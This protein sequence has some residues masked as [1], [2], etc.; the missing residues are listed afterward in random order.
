MEAMGLH[1]TIHLMVVEQGV[2]EQEALDLKIAVLLP[3]LV[4]C[5]N[6]LLLQELQC[7]MQLSLIHI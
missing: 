1:M 3:V 5:P 4:D 7:I 6:P 2:V